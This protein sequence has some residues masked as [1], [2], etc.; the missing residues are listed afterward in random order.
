MHASMSSRGI[1]G[2]SSALRRVTPGPIATTMHC[3]VRSL[4]DMVGDMACRNQRVNGPESP[5]VPLDAS[6][7]EARPYGRTTNAPKAVCSDAVRRFRVE[8]SVVVSKYARPTG[9][10]NSLDHS[11]AL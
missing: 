3:A 8:T 6:V 7:S 9:E 4:A 1:F 10:Q 5:P 11:H 2:N